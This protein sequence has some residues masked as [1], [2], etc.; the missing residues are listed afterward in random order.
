[1]K[2]S[3]KVV[4]AGIL[5]MIALTAG[6]TWVFAH[7]GD[8]DLVH[9]CV[10]DDS[11]GIR[12]VGPNEECKSKESALDWPAYNP[13]IPP[14]PPVVLG[15]YTRYNPGVDCSDGV[16]CV[17]VAVCD[18]GD[19]VSGGGFVRDATPGN[20]GVSV[21]ESRPTADYIWQVIL[22]NYSG[23]SVFFRAYARCADMTP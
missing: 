11:G 2:G 17:A 23:Q 12:I 19:A 21:V 16:N 22:A 8:P 15:F 14:A 3:G 18:P 6:A 5:L 4:L 1:M 7:G 13:E 9:A 20:P 10:N